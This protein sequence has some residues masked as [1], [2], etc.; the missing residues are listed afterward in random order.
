LKELDPKSST[1]KEF[2]PK[3]FDVFRARSLISQT[4]EEPS[5]HRVCPPPRLGKQAE[6]KEELGIMK[7]RFDDALVRQWASMKRA[8]VSL[9]TWIEV[10]REVLAIYMESDDLEAIVKADGDVL[11]V[12]SQVQRLATSTSIGHALFGG[13]LEEVEAAELSK[14]MAACVATLAKTKHTSADIATCKE[15]M[16]ELV[17]K[18]PTTSHFKRSVKINFLEHVVELEVADAMVEWQL[19]LNGHLKCQLLHQS[20][21]FPRLPYE[22]WFLPN[23]RALHDGLQVRGAGNGGHLPR[24]QSVASALPELMCG[25]DCFELFF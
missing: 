21:E 19:Q 4:L 23:A 15:A 10:H 3:E 22:Q 6:F 25:V 17:T 1:P 24:R 8:G 14:G 18:C 5:P 16:M 7:G 13:C 20:S 12:S 2:G 9:R 11:A